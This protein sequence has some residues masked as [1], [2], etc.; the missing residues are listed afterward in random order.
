MN[1]LH[2]RVR[3]LKLRVALACAVLPPGARAFHGLRQEADDLMAE[4]E[5][6]GF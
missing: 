1:V 2:L 5:A 6:R 4:A 3:W